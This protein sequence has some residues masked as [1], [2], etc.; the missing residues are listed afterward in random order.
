MAR[1][2]TLGVTGG[3]GSGKTTVCRM[4]AEM[5]AAVFYADDAARTL[6]EVDCDIRRELMEAFGSRCY[7]QDGSLDRGYLGGIVFE[8]RDY[9]SRLNAIVHPRVHQEFRRRHSLTEAALL[10]HEAALIFESGSDAHLDLVAVVDAPLEVRYG[11]IYR[12]DGLSCEAIQARMQHQLPRAE[13]LQRADWVVDNSRTPDDLRA[14]A[15]R[16]FRA[17]TVP[18]PPVV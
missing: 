2:K 13:L 4:L 7:R 12:R 16:L 6:M 3:I 1:P 15:A 10:V 8:S 14:E 18:V 5:G 11:R 17:A 9:V